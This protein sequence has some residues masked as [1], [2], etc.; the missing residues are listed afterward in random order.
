MLTRCL[1]CPRQLVITG[2]SSIESTFAYFVAKGPASREHPDQAALTVTRAVLNAME[3]F[4]WK[5][6]LRR[7]PPPPPKHACIRP[8]S[9]LLGTPGAQTSVARVSHT[10]PRSARTSRVAWSRT[11]CTSH[12]TRTPRSSPSGSSL[13]SSSRARCASL[14]E[15]DCRGAHA[16]TLFD[17]LARD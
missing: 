4:L 14:L 6:A 13:A 11:A 9:H 12:P 16:Y 1:L 8:C 3:G 5:C 7:P 17:P 15:A 2:V 10:A